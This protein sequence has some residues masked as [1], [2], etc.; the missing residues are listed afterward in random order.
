[1]S[2]RYSQWMHR[3]RLQSATVV[4]ALVTAVVS[5]SCASLAR[6]AYKS[7]VVTLKE[8]TVSGLGLTGGS[9]DVALSIYNP[10]GYK[11]EAL[12]MTYQLEVDSTRLGDGAL[13]KLFVVQAGDSSVVH[14]PVRF[15][16][17]AL[18]AVGRTLL[19][20]GMINYRVHGDFTVGT[21]VGNFTRPY[22]QKGRYSSI[23]GKSR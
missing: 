2:V 18:G 19:N 5:V 10:N 11:L 22:D 7:P 23:I 15:T 12:A 6:G 1:M 20:A 3:S 4:A 14:L 13:D 21:P 9:V 8:V 16:Y 17:A